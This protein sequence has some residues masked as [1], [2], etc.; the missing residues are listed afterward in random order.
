MHTYIHIVFYS[1]SGEGG[2]GGWGGSLHPA[3]DLV[4]V[5]VIRT[6]WDPASALR[7]DLATFDGPAG[8]LDSVRGRIKRCPLLPAGWTCCCCGTSQ[9]LTRTIVVLTL[10]KCRLTASCVQKGRRSS[11]HLYVSAPGVSIFTLEDMK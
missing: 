8:D 2:T 6:V 3:S 11:S 10:S 7:L 9:V 5:E 4:Q 1:S